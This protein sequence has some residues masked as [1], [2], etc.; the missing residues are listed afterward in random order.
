MKS[1][2]K[3]SRCEVGFKMGWMLESGEERGG[4]ERRGEARPGEGCRTPGGGRVG[5]EW[6]GPEKAVS[7][8]TDESP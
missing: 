8:R 6:E 4:E 3:E 2:M 7:I 1:F 5:A